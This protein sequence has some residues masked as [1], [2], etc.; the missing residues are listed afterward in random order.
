MEEA[1]KGKERR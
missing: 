1:T